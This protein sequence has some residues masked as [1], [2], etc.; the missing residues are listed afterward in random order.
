M[1]IFPEDL[2]E[3]IRVAIGPERLLELVDYRTE[4][5]QHLGQT[6]KAYCPI[7]REP[8]FRTLL[9]DVESRT[10]RCSN[11]QCEGHDGG[12]MIDLFARSRGLGYEEALPELAQAFGVEVDLSVAEDYVTRAQEIADNYFEMEAWDDAEDQYQR[13]L[14]FQPASIPALRGLLA[15]LRAKGSAADTSSIQLRLARELAG[16]DENSEAA[17]LLREYVGRNPD[18]TPTRLFYIEC[19]KKVGDDQWVAGE[20]INLADY[21]TAQGDI[22]Q[23]LEIYR[24]IEKMELTA[25]DVSLHIVQILLSAGRRD[26]AIG[27]ILK[28]VEL[29]VAA[30]DSSGAL[31]RIGQALEI[32]GERED[33]RVT[34]CQIIAQH[35]PKD[36]ELSLAFA[37]VRSMLASHSHGPASQALDELLGAFEGNMALIELK[38]DLEEA[39][40][41]QEAALEMRLECVD[42]YEEREDLALALAT[43]DKALGDRV[44]NV[45]LLSRRAGLLRSLGRTE[46]ALAAYGVIVDMFESAEEFDHA[47]AVYQT[48]IDLEPDN[49]DHRVQQF[50]LYLRLGLEPVVVKTALELAEAF[51]T[52]GET[53]KAVDVLG[54]AFAVA[55]E[56]PEA[57]T[58]HGEILEKL[59]RKAEAA[60]QFYAV[61]RLFSDQQL[62]DRARHRLERALACVPEHMEAREIRADVLVHQDMT[63]QAMGEY[64]ELAQAY[65]TAEE[66]ESVVRI[67]EKILSLQPDHLS[68]LQLLVLAYGQSGDIER[69]RSSQLRLVQLYRQNQSYTRAADLCSEIL[70]SD[71]DFTPALEQLIAITEQTHQSANTIKHLWNLAGVYARSGKREEEQ[72]ILDRILALDPLYPPAWTRHLD[73]LSQWASPQV[74]ADAVAMALDHFT[75]ATRPGEIIQILDKLRTG[76]TPKPEILAGLARLRR[77]T[78][79]AEGLKDAL[80]QQAALLTKA[81]RNAEAIGVF[82]ELVELEPDDMAILRQRIELMIRA[83]RRDEACAEYKRL[84]QVYIERNRIEEAETA[85]NEALRID[86]GDTEA[87]EGIIGLFIRLKDEE[88]AADAIEDLAGLY[89][90]NQQYDLAV[91]AYERIFE[92]DPKREEVFR[93]IIGLKQRS[94]DKDGAMAAYDRLLDLLHEGGRSGAFEQTATE[95]LALE[96]TNWSI[97]RRLADHL[98]S[99]SRTGEAEAALLELAGLQLKADSLDSVEQTLAEVLELNPDSIQ[100]RAFRAELLAKQGDTSSALSEFRSLTSS[101]G[102]LRGGP[103]PGGDMQAPF[104]FGNYEGL[105]RVKEYTFDQFVVGGRN[106]FAHASALAVARAPG[107][108]YNPLFLYADVGL[109]KTHLCHAMANHV[110]DHHPDL[111][112]MYTMTEDFIGGLIDGI[113]NNTITAFRNRH[114]LTDVLIIDDIQFLSGK[115]RAQEEF[116][117]IFNA[118]F[119]A[120]K[121]IV[122]TSDR[123]P[124]DISH[125][126]KRLRSRFG[127]GIIVDIQAPDLETRIAI[128]RKE[129]HQRGVNDA[130]SDDVVLYIGENVTENIRE[131]KGAL[132]QVLASADIGGQEIDMD[133]AR[134]VV[135]QVGARA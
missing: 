119:Q 40:G 57:L 23:A 115:E 74:L 3:Q 73:L 9:V 12:D 69:Q 125:L 38:G 70:A 61:G 27:E 34:Y 116:F 67:A 123:P 62:Y 101:L 30:G 24:R 93:K 55:P 120:G 99:L 128:V 97:H 6:I 105:S 14:R 129:L 103:G 91:A 48:I 65:L 132:N 88:R 113:Q 82:G 134:S 1:H 47:A 33:L 117:H 77:E 7:H 98:K 2:I 130:I 44:D 114:R 111:K 5:I 54:R 50:D 106:N 90:R 43:L 102:K 53:E 26:E 21:L 64:G 107:R 51:E 52:E 96:P 41:H 95:A 45:A 25:I 71:E 100:G 81:T 22:E 16:A 83:D 121:Q 31:E 58:R 37:H 36:A 29:A 79:D 8:I 39:R 17:E 94:G 112:V 56:S 20:Y 131:L 28:R 60:Q 104:Q 18:D 68:T 92:F 85:W 76:P 63:L 127:A 122:I 35:P 78:G 108:N 118:L 72:S 86:P 84:A 15:V 4:M 110:L 109:G 133:L 42:A 135:E 126:E 80:R 59:G 89:T 66:P 49:I 19:V 13:I 124:K 11:K 32:D 75:K 10:Y 87:R 46:D